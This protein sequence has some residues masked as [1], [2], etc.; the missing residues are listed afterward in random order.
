MNDLACI[1][2]MHGDNERVRKKLSRKASFVHSFMRK[3]REMDFCFLKDIFVSLSNLSF[4]YLFVKLT[5]KVAAVFFLVLAAL[6]L[7][8]TWQNDEW[9]L[10]MSTFSHP[11]RVKHVNDENS[12]RLTQESLFQRFLLPSFLKL[13][14]QNFFT[15]KVPTDE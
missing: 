15:F 1:I 9:K 6:G 4:F 12:W 13:Q 5:E 8:A 7:Q 2:L 11:V 3:K 10:V 14:Q